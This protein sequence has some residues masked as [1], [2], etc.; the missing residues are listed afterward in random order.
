MLVSAQSGLP[1][2]VKIGVLNFHLAQEPTMKSTFTLRSCGSFLATA[3]LMLFLFA[4]GA[5]ALAGW[6]PDNDGL[7]VDIAAVAE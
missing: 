5:S 3:M 6:M 7:P 4:T 2:K 1:A